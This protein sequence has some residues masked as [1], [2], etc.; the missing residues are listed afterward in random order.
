MIVFFDSGIFTVLGIG[1][2]VLVL[3]SG[4]F[5]VWMAEHAIWVEIVWFISHIFYS[6]EVIQRLR[7][8][9]ESKDVA[10]LLGGLHTVLPIFV[11]LV[12]H[13]Y[14]LQQIADVGALSAAMDYAVCM[15]VYFAAGRI[16]NKLVVQDQMGTVGAFVLTGLHVMVSLFFFVA[17]A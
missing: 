13:Q 9:M 15:G 10:L 12:G 2:L 11:I 8:N 6:A 5:A 1:L 3:V 17:F 4:S 16:W 7:G 14:L